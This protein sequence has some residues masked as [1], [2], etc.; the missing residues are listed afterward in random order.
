MTIAY[1]HVQSCR[2]ATLHLL[3]SSILHSSTIIPSEARDLPFCKKTVCHPEPNLERS[4]RS[5]RDL[6]FQGSG[7][8]QGSYFGEG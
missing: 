5:A 6:V 1:N 8:R 3:P 4:E 7:K 2:D